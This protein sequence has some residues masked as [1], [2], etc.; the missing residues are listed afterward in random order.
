MTHAHASL[1]SRPLGRFPIGRQLLRHGPETAQGLFLVLTCA[2]LAAY[3]LGSTAVRRPLESVS[4]IFFSIVLEALPFML[5]G[6]LVG[7][8]IETLVS[9]ERMVALFHGRRT[10]LI[11]LAPLM[12]LIF[13]VCE[14]AVIPVIR[15]LLRK[16]APFSATLAFMLAGPLVNPLVACSTAVAYRFDWTVVA[17]RLG[18]DYGIAVVLGLMAEWITNGTDESLVLCSPSQSH[19]LAAG[20]TCCAHRHSAPGRMSKLAA[21]LRHAADDFLGVAR[22][23]V[24]GAFVAGLLRGL[25]CEAALLRAAAGN[26]GL[27]IVVMMALAVVLNLCSEAD[28]FVAASFRGMV[29][30]AGQLAFMILGPMLDIK[31]L[32]MYVGVF[33]KR[34]IIILAVAVIMMVFIAVALTDIVVGG[35]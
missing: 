2:L 1:T 24:V 18:L 30:L 21:I 31:L 15:R 14:C 33:R 13:P 35:L 32:L 5:V 34:A 28:A 20:C 12:G 26:S 19:E 11:L 10:R 9:R 29:P 17:L 8:V 22:Y 4:T 27:A 6:S 23:L 7:G 25:L 3:W 16:G